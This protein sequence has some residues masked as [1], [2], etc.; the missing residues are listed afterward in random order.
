MKD[1]ATSSGV[2]DPRGSR[3]ISMQAWLLGSLLAGINVQ[4][5]NKNVVTV[6]EVTVPEIWRKQTKVHFTGCKIRGVN[7]PIFMLNKPEI[8]DRM[9]RGTA[10][11]TVNE[12]CDDD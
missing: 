4:T 6:P 5:A 11:G 2:F 8:N 9:D 10:L 7:S 1:S 3:Q 12:T